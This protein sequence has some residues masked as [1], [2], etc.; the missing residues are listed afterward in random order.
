VNLVPALVGVKLATFVS[1]TVIGVVPAT[2]AFAFFGS[3]LD[4]VIVMQ[5]V[6]YR[7]CV[8]SGR[9]DCAVHFDIGMVATRK[10]L[11]AFVALGALALVP[12]AVKRLRARSE[13][14]RRAAL[15]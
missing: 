11:A 14:T 15:S 9:S 8:A 12:V 3:G 13:A 6:A 1:A 4:S 10:L 2:F 5:E 7:A